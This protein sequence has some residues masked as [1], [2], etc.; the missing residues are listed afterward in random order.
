MKK[1]FGV[2]WIVVTLFVLSTLFLKAD[3]PWLRAAPVSP[4]SL[5]F[6]NGSR[7]GEPGSTV[8]A[9]VSGD[10]D[11]DGDVDLVS[12]GDKINGWENDGSPF[13]STW[14][15]TTLG[16]PGITSYALAT[17]DFDN[18][19]DL[20]NA[21]GSAWLTGYEVQVWQNDSTPFDATWVSNGV[22]N[23]DAVFVLVSGDL[24]GDGYLDLVSG[25]DGAALMAW[26]NDAT[27]FAGVWT[28]LYVGS[29]STD[30]TAL[31]IGDLDND[32]D[33]DLVSG[34]AANRV[35]AWENDGTPFSGAWSMSIVFTTTD[36]IESLLLADVDAD[37]DLDIL[38]GVGMDEDYELLEE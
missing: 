31:A 36:G 6:G 19:G 24:D 14:A 27:P 4:S 35:S 37:G 15:L 12:A 33:L 8:Q 17:G 29:V 38:A 16:S 18:D 1:L 9:L 7:V 2:F 3:G 21:S 32:G 25:D 5:L 10:L 28:S 13:T 34:N 23:A 30:V 22:G 26:R 11:N 20:D